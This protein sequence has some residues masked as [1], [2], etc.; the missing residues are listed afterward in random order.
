MEWTRGITR[1]A[2]LTGAGIS[3]DSGVP[4]Y[5]GPN[6][7][8]T[9]DPAAA[10]AFTYDGFLADPA[11]RARFWDTYAGHSAWL[12]EPNGAHRALAE[13]DGS[14]TAVRVL[15]QNVDGLHQRAGLPARKV[16]ELHGTIRAV[17][18]TGCHIRTDT[19]RTLL[20]VRMG[21]SDP[22]CDACGAS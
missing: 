6:G 17:R 16:L 4:D 5:R 11:L 8:W 10:R 15:T 14:G 21:H 3:T 7:I 12:A 1:V 19:E 2:V 9:R 20:R 18:C 13:L 22:R